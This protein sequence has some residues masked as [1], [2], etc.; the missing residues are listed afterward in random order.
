MAKAMSVAMGTVRAR[1]LPPPGATTWQ[2]CEQA[3]EGAIH[4]GTRPK[5]GGRRKGHKNT[6]KERAGTTSSAGVRGEEGRL[7]ASCYRCA[8][9]AT[10]RG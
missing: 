9:I 10:G 8:P 1:R 7:A 3:G 5:G 6:G 4:I 2:A